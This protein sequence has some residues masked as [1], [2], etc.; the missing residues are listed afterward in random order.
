MITPRLLIVEDERIIARNVAQ[1]LTKL[2]YMMVAIVGSGREAVQQA[3]DLCL[4]LLLMDIG[5]PGEMD[6]LKAAAHTQA[7]VNIPI[8]Y[9]TGSREAEPHSRMSAAA[10]HFTIRKPVSNQTLQQTLQMAL[11]TISR[12]PP[13]GATP[14][15]DSAGIT[16]STLGRQMGCRRGERLRP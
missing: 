5:L 16:A 9:L 1:R 2:G 13:G 3:S 15:G 7:Q 6:E 12:A 11:A 8:I 14:R 10:P 4:D